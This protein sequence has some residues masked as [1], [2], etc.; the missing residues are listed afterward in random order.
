MNTP[1]I[2]SGAQLSGRVHSVLRFESR[3]LWALRRR[4]LARHGNPAAWRAVRGG[5]FCGREGQY[6][7]LDAVTRALIDRDVARDIEEHPEAW[8]N[9]EIAEVVEERPAT[10][11]L[12]LDA[13]FDNFFT[14]ALGIGN[15]TRYCAVGTGTATPAVS[16]TG[17]GSEVARTGTMIT[18]SGNC[19]TSYASSAFTMRRTHDFA[20]VSSPQNFTELIWSH[21]STA[22]ANANIRVLISG[23]T[24]SLT[25]GQ[26]LRTVHDLTANCSPTTTQSGTITVAN[27][28]MGSATSTAG[29]W[30]WQ[31]LGLSTVDING[32]SIMTDSYPTSLEPVNGEG[33]AVG[34][35]GSC[36]LNT[37]R[38]NA[39][40]GTTLASIQTG[41]A[42]STYTPGSFSRSVQFGAIAAN[43]CVSTAI[44]A[45]SIARWR[46]YGDGVFGPTASSPLVVRFNEL[47]T[48]PDTH[49]LR[50]PGFTLTLSR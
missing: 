42:W 25:T 20:P 26:Q 31:A 29:T 5:E 40:L 6:L 21:V 37:W 35:H 36:T 12:V 38:T 46:Y 33:W 4:G 24:V 2:K 16:D 44:R 22:G 27:W 14:G 47:Q 50:I 39:T 45:F 3:R 19:G 18:G 23:G 48:K 34:V 43:A 30:A 11:N 1:I 8:R 7:Q 9:S 49:T 32:N 13:C 10:C 28:P 15:I 41:G 17:L